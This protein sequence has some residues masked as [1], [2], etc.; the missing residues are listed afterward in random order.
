VALDPV[1]GGLV[2]LE[3]GRFVVEVQQVRP[4]LRDLFALI[5]QLPGTAGEPL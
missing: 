4:M 5:R 2:L 1:G 3:S